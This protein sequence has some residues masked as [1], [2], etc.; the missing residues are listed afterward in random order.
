[1][2]TNAAIKTPFVPLNNDV[3]LSPIVG[4]VERLMDCNS[5]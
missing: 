3:T 2:D 4:A 1:V 5:E